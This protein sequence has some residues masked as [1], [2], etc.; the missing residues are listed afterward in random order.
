MSKRKFQS[1]AQLRKH[2][3]MSELYKSTLQQA[4]AAGQVSLVQGERRPRAGAP[5]RVWARLGARG[6][7][8][9]ALSR[10]G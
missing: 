1:E 9:A 10:A 6:S 8:A 4:I 3:E 5:T 7:R 2:V